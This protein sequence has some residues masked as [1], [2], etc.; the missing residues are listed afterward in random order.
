MDTID[1]LNQ[2]VA[3]FVAMQGRNR[4]VAGRNSSWSRGCAGIPIDPTGV[5]FVLDPATG[6]IDVDRR[7]RSGPCRPS[8][9]SRSRR[10]PP[11]ERRHADAPAV[12]DHAA[13]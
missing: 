12:D 6:R 4:P 2:D 3:R 10:S 11:H 5:P 9:R 1:G 13:W 7:S 8:S